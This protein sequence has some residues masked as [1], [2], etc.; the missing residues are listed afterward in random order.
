MIQRYAVILTPGHTGSA[1]L[2]KLLNSHFEVMCF[3]E[4]DFLSYTLDWP[5]RVRGYFEFTLEERLRNLLYMFSPSHRY[6]DSYQA[7]GAIT[8]GAE[9]SVR[10]TMEE[11]ALS[12]PAAAQRTRFF[13][14]TRNPVSQIDSHTAGLA[15]MAQCVSDEMRMRDFHR[16]RSREVL[17]QMKPCPAQALLDEL[18]QGDADAEYFLHAC[19][20]YVRLIW[21]AQEAQTMLPK[22]VLRL[23]DLSHDPASLRDALQEITGLEYHLSP[24]WTDK[25][26]VKSGGMPPATLFQ[27]W[28]P[29][30]RGY[31]TQVFEPQQQALATLS[32]DLNQLIIGSGTRC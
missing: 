16:Q 22:S 19:F 11:V 2:G 7:L 32:Y 9:L 29:Q 6:G 31:F 4:P 15:Q 10:R 26:N 14:L 1:W 30:R 12:F 3:H 17:S 23:E 18:Q 13:V 27:S 28:S 8:A 24:S 25:I 5:P 20:D 21:A